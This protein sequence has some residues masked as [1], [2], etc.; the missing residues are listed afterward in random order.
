MAGIERRPEQVGLT[1]EQPDLPELILYRLLLGHHGQIVLS[2]NLKAEYKR[3]ETVKV[4]FCTIKDNPGE[5]AVDHG[6]V[7]GVF[8]LS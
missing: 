1:V 3:S 8:L 7:A 5:Y 6:G 4:I 2:I